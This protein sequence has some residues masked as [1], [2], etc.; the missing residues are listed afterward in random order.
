MEMS[1]LSP[2]VR[3]GSMVA[4]LFD[5]TKSFDE[6]LEGPCVVRPVGDSG[7]LPG[8]HKQASTNKQVLTRQARCYFTCPTEV[9]L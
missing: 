2:A 6:G 8:V 5:A 1:R 9:L 3:I 4:A 7:V